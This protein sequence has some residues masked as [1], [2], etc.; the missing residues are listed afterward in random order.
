MVRGLCDVEII[1]SNLS[2]KKPSKPSTHLLGSYDPQ[3]G[4]IGL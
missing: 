2:K 4:F 1:G 3:D